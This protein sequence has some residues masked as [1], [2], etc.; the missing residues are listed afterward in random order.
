MTDQKEVPI[1]QDDKALEDGAP[2]SPS[3]TPNDQTTEQLDIFE[4][5]KTRTKLRIT[6][7]I[8]ALNVLKY[9]PFSSHPAIA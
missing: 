5:P 9:L 7:I 2:K 6:A 1:E 4:A 3:R 8:I